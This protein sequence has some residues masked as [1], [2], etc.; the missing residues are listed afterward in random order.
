MLK[1]FFGNDVI[2][3]REA[4]SAYLSELREQDSELDVSRLEPENYETGQLASL[5]ET[6]PLFGGSKVYLVDTPSLLAPFW[7]EVLAEIETL[8]RS[9]HTFILLEGNI[10]AAD[11]KKITK[12]IDDLTEFKSAAKTEFNAFQLAEV[13]ARKDKRLLWLLLAEARV[14]GLSA[15][16]M[17]GI[18]WWQLKTLRLANLTRSAEEAGVKDY[19]YNKAKKAL[20]NF[21]SGEVEG[22]SLSLLS[23]YHDGHLGK[24]D[25]DLALEEWALRL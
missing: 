9:Q 17:I 11:K 19:P 12:F 10:L 15:E 25:I 22:L 24:R 8:E 16:E 5:S 1:V 23:L 20:S 6:M 4:A 7:E 18:I 21:K 14:S 2:R 13:T 3:V